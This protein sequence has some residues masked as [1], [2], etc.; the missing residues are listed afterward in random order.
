VK[1]VID[2]VRVVTGVDFEVQQAPRRAGDPAS[3]VANGNRLMRLGWRPELN[4]LATIV[5][6][7]YEWEKKPG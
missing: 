2:T 7:A 4:D 5:Q 6:H 1:Q 3:I